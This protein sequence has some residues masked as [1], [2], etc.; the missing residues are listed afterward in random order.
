MLTIQ[1]LALGDNLLLRRHAGLSEKEMMCFEM[2]QAHLAFQVAPGRNGH[3]LK[4]HLG[5]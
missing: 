3:R 5:R 1:S 2:Y 4:I